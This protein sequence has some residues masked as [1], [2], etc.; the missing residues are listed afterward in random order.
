LG[1]HSIANLTMVVRLT[2]FPCLLPTYTNPLTT[3]VLTKCWKG[4]L[5]CKE[6]KNWLGW[7][8]GFFQK[9][10]TDGYNKIKDP[11][12]SGS[13]GEVFL[14]KDKLQGWMEPNDN[15]GVWASSTSESCFQWMGTMLMAVGSLWPF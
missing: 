7:A 1:S 9:P 3:H 11:P 8:R 5:F 2:Q 14:L 15:S 13:V 12:N 6:R 10:R 4:S